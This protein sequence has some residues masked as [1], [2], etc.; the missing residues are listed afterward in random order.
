MKD[1]IKD[2]NL[3]ALKGKKPTALKSKETFILGKDVDMKFSILLVGLFHGCS[4]NGCR[5][6]SSLNLV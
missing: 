3:S 1:K 6:R 4:K 2:S 5:H